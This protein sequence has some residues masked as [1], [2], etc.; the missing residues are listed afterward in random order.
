MR[1]LVFVVTHP[2]TASHLLRGQLAFF[3]E[4]GFD[5][6]VISSPGPELELVAERE[7]VRVVA[8][9]M[10]RDI[11]FSEGP[12]AVV[13]LTRA[14]RSLRPQI[15]NA[16]TPKAGLLGMIAARALSVPVRV[17]LLRGLRLEGEEGRARVALLGGAE[18]VASACAHRVV[19]VSESLRRVYV[20]GGYAPKDKTS[21]IP[22]NGIDVGRF[23][24]RAE[25]REVAARVRAR[26]GIDERA[27]VAGFVGRVTGDK[28]IADLIEAVDRA[29]LLVPK[30]KM[31]IV[32]GDLA[33]DTLP[34]DLAGRLR[35]HPGFLFA[36]K[37]DDPAPYY[38]AMDL[39][40]FPSYREGLPNVPLEAAACELPTV[41]YQSTGMMDAIDHGATGQLV[42]RGDAAALGDALVRYASAP[43]LRRAHGAA[44]RVRVRDHFTNERTWAAWLRLY[45]ELLAAHKR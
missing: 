37:V 25:S 33:G 2:T 26:L 19:C 7:R 1:R 28:G 5:V 16:S 36:G 29:A 20:Q 8:V 42:T 21:V 27:F 30:L 11:R 40:V 23:Q 39:L 38:A 22:S 4:H 9:P 17:Y 43:E 3:R 41:G 15:V 6:T 45:E 34:Q 13:A 32:G 24:A 31:L 44:A 14:L 18:R 35:S 10:S 12:R